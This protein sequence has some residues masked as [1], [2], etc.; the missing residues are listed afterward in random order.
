[1]DRPRFRRWDS[2]AGF[3]NYSEVRDHTGFSS[4]LVGIFSDDCNAFAVMFMLLS[5]SMWREYTWK[6]VDI[7]SWM[8]VC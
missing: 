4:L 1:M 7:D 5:I 8:G 3:W 2:W 6:V